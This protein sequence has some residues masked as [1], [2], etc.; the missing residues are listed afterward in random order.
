MNKRWFTAVLNLMSCILIVGFFQ[1]SVS[2]AAPSS[3]AIGGNT[4]DN[5]N[6]GALSMSWEFQSTGSFQGASPVA[7]LGHIFVANKLGQ[8]VALD[9]SGLNGCTYNAMDLCTPQYTFATPLNT[10]VYATPVVS[11]SVLF[12][13]VG[14]VVDAFDALG[15][16]N[17]SGT[18]IICTPLW[19]TAQMGGVGMST[20]VIFG[21]SII[22]HDSIGLYSFST[23]GLDCSSLPLVCNPEWSSPYGNQSYL[24]PALYNSTLFTTSGGELLAFDA[25]GVANCSGVPDVCNPE[26]TAQSAQDEFGVVVNNSTG[27][28]FTVSNFIYGFDANGVTKCSLGSCLPIWQGFDGANFSQFYSPVEIFGNVLYIEGLNELYAYNLTSQ[29]TCLVSPFAECSPNWEYSV[30]TNLSSTGPSSSPI[31]ANGLLFVGGSNGSLYVFPS[32]G[33]TCPVVALIPQ[34]L[35]LKTMSASGPIET[36]PMYYGGNVYVASSNGTLYA[37]GNAPIDLNFSGSSIAS[38][39][40]SQYPLS[41]SFSPDTYNYAIYCGGISNSITLSV[42]GTSSA[43]SLQGTSNQTFTINGQISANQALVVVAPSP[44]SFSNQDAQY[45][46]RCLPPHFPYLTVSKY[47]P[48]QDGYYLTTFLNTG[49]S[50]KVVLDSNGVP[51]WYQSGTG[52]EFNYLGNGN[53]STL[54]SNAQ[55]FGNGFTTFNIAEHNPD[56]EDYS[57]IHKM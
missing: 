22:V 23:T 54:V 20:P 6:I 51:V 9:A 8:V 5:Q 21:S 28:V 12:V 1:T 32:D 43:L 45:W 47:A 48:V 10:P 17:C 2:Y 18:P 33:S 13:S 40:I 50:E 36:S 26:W 27:E 29:S 52:T 57:H 46:I 31:V 53:F 24:P 16:Q 37:M 34:C 11:G 55:L 15:S 39:D 19:S 7:A 3:V 30:A 4:L 44:S 41:P 42:G 56:T 35:S 25:N 14:D 49:Y 38:L